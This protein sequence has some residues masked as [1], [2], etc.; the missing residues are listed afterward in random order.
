M[1]DNSRVDLLFVEQEPT[2]NQPKIVDLFNNPSDPT[3]APAILPQGPTAPTAQIHPTSAP[4]TYLHATAWDVTKGPPP[5]NYV[6]RKRPA[7]K[8]GADQRRKVEMLHNCTCAGVRHRG[9]RQRQTYKQNRRRRL[10]AAQAPQFIVHDGTQAGGA[11]VIP[12]DLDGE[13]IILTAQYGSGS[14]RT[15][16]NTGG[17]AVGRLGQAY[18]CVPGERAGGGGHSSH[19]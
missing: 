19:E 9:I 4:S 2:T 7:D 1:D 6:L 5:K 10:H 13:S 16:S 8:M 3:V 15:C 18:V 12:V 17:A 11:A 14:E